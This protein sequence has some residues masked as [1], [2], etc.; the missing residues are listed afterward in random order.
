LYFLG[1]KP[2]VAEKF[3]QDLKRQFPQI[4]IVGMQHGYF[5]KTAGCSENI[6]VIQAINNAHPDLLVIGLG[7]LTQERWLSENWQDL[8]ARV[9]L[10]VGAMFDYLAGVS[11]RAPSWMTDHGLEWLGRLL[12]EP[13]RLAERYLVG[14]PR[15]IFA[16]AQQRLGHRP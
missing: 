2:G 5:D 15:F 1:A 3:A 14:N 12:V 7:M 13:R 8:N 6:A 16:I 4:K 9:A 10:P 11:P